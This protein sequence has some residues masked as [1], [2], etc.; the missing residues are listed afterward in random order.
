[1]TLNGGLQRYQ[2]WIIYDDPFIQIN[3]NLQRSHY[4]KLSAT[5]LYIYSIKQENTLDYK[6]QFFHTWDILITNLDC[7]LNLLRIF[8]NVQGRKRDKIFL[9]SQIWIILPLVAK[10][11]KK[12]LMLIDLLSFAVMVWMKVYT[13]FI[14]PSIIH[15]ISCK[16]R[17]SK[18]KDS[19]KRKIG[20]FL[21]N[22]I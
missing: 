22:Q 16:K 15:R 4:V 13:K 6:V 9:L 17:E 8:Q 12:R 1:M 7:I 20:M 18:S 21:N 10:L 19:S 14:E 5:W 11:A 2:S 3:L